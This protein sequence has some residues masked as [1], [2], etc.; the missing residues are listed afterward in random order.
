MN[1]FI[2]SVWQQSKSCVHT[3][4]SV[5]VAVSTICGYKRGIYHCSLLLKNISFHLSLSSSA[6]KVTFP[7]QLCLAM[8]HVFRSLT[9]T[10]VLIFRICNNTISIADVI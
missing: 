9:V 6:Y 8:S 2:M 1:Y 4:F 7:L 3:L 5:Q 10:S